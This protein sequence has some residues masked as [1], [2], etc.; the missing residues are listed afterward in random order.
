MIDTKKYDLSFYGI[1]LQKAKVVNGQNAIRAYCPKCHESRRNVHKKERELYVNLDNGCC[2]CHNCGADWRMDTREYQERKAQA[3]QLARRPSTYTRPK[4]AAEPRYADRF[5][6]KL[7]GYLCVT[8]QLSLDVLRELLVT[9]EKCFMPQSGREED[10][11][12]FNYYEQG[13]LI[14]RKYRSGRK[15]FKMEKG[16]ELIPYNLDS[17]L[18]ELEVIITEGEI[19]V[20]SLLT[21]GFKSVVS[22]PSG[23]NGNTDFLNRVYDFYFGDKTWILIATDMDAPGVKCAEELV[24]RFGPERCKRVCFSEGCKDANEELVKKGAESLRQ[25]IAEAQP[26]PLQDIRTVESFEEELDAFYQNGPQSGVPT[27]WKNFDRIVSF[28]TG[29]LALITGRTN[30]GKSEW[31]DELVLRLLLRTDWNVGY[32]S[33]ENTL[34]DHARKLIEKLADRSFDNRK[35]LGVSQG[36]FLRCKQFMRERMNW[37]DLPFS[38]QRLATLQA[39]ALTLV[40][41]MG[42]RMLVLDPYNFIL[43]ENNAQR[44]ENAWDSYVIGSLRD[45]AIQNNL[46][47][48]LVAHPRKVEMMLDGRKRRITLE[49]ISGTA[50][51][52]NKADYVF[53]VDRD[54]EHG[55]VTLSVDKVRRKQYGSKG[56]QAF[57]VYKAVSGRYCPCE[58]DE[59]HNPVNTDWSSDS[60][61]WLKELDLFG[62]EA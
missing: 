53:C 23:A 57:F 40:R 2:H 24:R 49:D 35:Q 1:S 47:I 43:K 6:E 46:L 34:M 52:G 28:A 22:L 37:I 51:F 16:A 4:P 11:V 50:D 17:C 38:E 54:D 20:L 29:Q 48:F 44:S 13:V 55:L 56:K 9:E 14:N 61:F 59:E 8:R 58:R 10:C 30:D 33:P 3:E 7:R 39:R 19:D 12:V 31:L 45:F 5:S 41:K 26:V 21:V 62:N 15:H 60:G 25:R 42:I 36:Q 32:W 27:G 18:N